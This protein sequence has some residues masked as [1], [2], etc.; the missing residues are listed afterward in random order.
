MRRYAL[1]QLPKEP[2]TYVALLAASLLAVITISLFLQISEYTQHT[3]KQLINNKEYLGFFITPLIFALIVYLDKKYTNYAGGSGIPQLIAA[4]DSRNKYLRIML[5][6]FKIAISKIIFVVLAM[7]AGASL[8]FGGPSVHIGGSIFYN[9][10]E[11]IKL[12]RKLLIQA[13]IAIG[14]SV[15]LIIAFNAPI[16]GVLFAYEEIGR[17]L[18]R[19]ALVLIAVISLFVYL[20]L[21]TYT[22][23][24]PYLMDLSNLSFNLGLIWQL[25]PLAI[26]GGI[27]GGIFAKVSLYLIRTFMFGKHTKVILLSA[28][29]GCLVALLNY[30]SSAQTSGSGHQE[31]MMILSGGQLGAEFALMKYLAT[32]ASFI[33]TIAGGLFMTSI[34]VGA[35]IGNEASY[36]Y[37]QIN[38][39]VIMIMAMIG[40]LSGV[41]RAPL[42]SALLVLEMTNSF[43]L[44]LPGILVALVASITSRQFSE[45]PI[46]E[47]L[48]DNY[49]KMTQK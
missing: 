36:L 25:L 45:Q 20:L 23:N 10:A 32:L 18:R 38:P 35:G 43:N 42:T 6:S 39:Q 24:T 27:L 46:Y 44:L 19:Q 3:F 49:L 2:K 40:Y 11:L 30:L 9:F 26:L 31:A 4:T 8:S 41:I 48:A 33:S 17:K 21:N 22:V 29:L 47:A 1:Y 13:V 7:V 34:S 14:G 37:S 5:L 15:G 28:F 12:K 16:A